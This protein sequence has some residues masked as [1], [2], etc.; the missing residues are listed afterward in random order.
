MAWSAVVPT[1]ARKQMMRLPDAAV[2]EIRRT[3]W[4]REVAFRT[5]PNVTKVRP[6]HPPPHTHTLRRTQQLFPRG[7]GMEAAL[8]A[9]LGTEQRTRER[10]RAWSRVPGPPA[11]VA[12]SPHGPCLLPHSHAR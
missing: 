12:L 2:E 7:V 1:H 10:R 4:T 9:S 8:H 11:V 3:G 5:T 6:T